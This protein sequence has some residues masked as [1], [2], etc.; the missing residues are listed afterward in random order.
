MAFSR[1]EV[2]LKFMLC[3]VSSLCFGWPRHVSYKFWS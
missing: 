2:L 3:S 1:M